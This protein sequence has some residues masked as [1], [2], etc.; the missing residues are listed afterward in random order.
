MFVEGRKLLIVLQLCH[1]VRRQRRGVPFHKELA[2]ENG[3]A[4]LLV[5]AFDGYRRLFVHGMTS[6]TSVLTRQSPSKK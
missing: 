3:L 1:W 5:R 2:V 4:L 6:E